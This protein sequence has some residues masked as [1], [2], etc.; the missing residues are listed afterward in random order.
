[1]SF[2][3]AG[4]IAFMLAF[5]LICYGVGRLILLLLFAKSAQTSVAHA[6][7]PVIGLMVMALQLWLYGLLR[8]PWSR[9]W[10]LLPWAVLGILEWHSSGRG[11]TKPWLSWRKAWN[12]FKGWGY[13]E[14]VLVV[15]TLILAA[16]FLVFMVQQS[17]VGADA[18]AVWAYKA[19]AFFVHQAVYVD[20]HLIDNLNNAR[21]HHID[22]PPLFPLMAD[23]AYVIW[24]SV[25][26]AFLK[27]LNFIFLVSGATSLAVFLRPLSGRVLT[28]TAV[29]LLV[30]LPQFHHILFINT[31]M[32]YADYALAITMLL[33]AICLL[34]SWG[35]RPGINWLLALFF[36]AM[37]SV[38]KNEG[39]PFFIVVVA[40]LALSWWQQR[41]QFKFRPKRVAANLGILILVALPLLAW[42]YYKSR[43]GIV[44]DFQFNNINLTGESVL[45]KLGRITGL[46]VLYVKTN[47][48]YHWQIWAAILGILA[49]VWYR[50]R[51]AWPL[52]AIVAFQSIFYV[53]SFL[54]SPYELR[55]H[56]L[57]SAD[58]LLLQLAPLTILLLAI[59]IVQVRKLKV[60]ASTT[61]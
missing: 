1:M 33:A 29:F 18:F 24:G 21:F 56:V 52:L 58:R 7:A 40:L 5:S 3:L 55:F 20:P 30:S 25:N 10:L 42:T 41:R 61:R 34:I 15:A 47:P 27:A 16:I 6:L 45:T 51:L 39:L 53:T 8:I 38:I 2:E 11:L 31:N 22:Y 12:K 48:I 4:L 54:F 32:G 26:E 23:V 60:K 57:S 46:L 14:T 13:F 19:K 36:A 35:Q 9:W 49:T 43:H 44:A 50:S 37:A 17:L 28:V 59:S